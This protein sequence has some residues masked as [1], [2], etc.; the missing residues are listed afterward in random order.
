MTWWQSDDVAGSRKTECDVS[1]AMGW[2]DAGPPD[3]IGSWHTYW[4]DLPVILLV[5]LTWTV[6]YP[7]TCPI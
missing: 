4:A 1:I 6:A 3:T 2:V 5:S 7:T